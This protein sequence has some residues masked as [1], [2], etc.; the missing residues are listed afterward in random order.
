MWLL[1]KYVAEYIWAPMLKL[2]NVAVIVCT[3][4][5]LLG[6]FLGGTGIFNNTQFIWPF[7]RR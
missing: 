7:Y 3:I 5:W 2:I 4:L 6:V 1:N